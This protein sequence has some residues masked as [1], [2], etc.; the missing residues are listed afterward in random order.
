MKPYFKFVNHNLLVTKHLLVVKT[1]ILIL[2]D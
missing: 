2:E 1:H